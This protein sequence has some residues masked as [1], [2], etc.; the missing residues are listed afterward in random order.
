MSQLSQPVDRREET[1]PADSA[2]VSPTELIALLNDEYVREI[3]ARIHNE[4]KPARAL[5][6][7]CDVSRPTVYRRLNRLQDAG[8]VKEGMQYETNG[9]HRRTFRLAVEEST[10]E[11]AES[12]FEAEVQPVGPGEA[13]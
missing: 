10:L 11:L 6:E 9:H 13:V 3:L 7:E 2:T 8:L 4:A 5:A 1:T 12:G